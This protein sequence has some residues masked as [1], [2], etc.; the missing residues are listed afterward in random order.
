[1]TEDEQTPARVEARRG[2]FPVVIGRDVSVAQAGGQLF[3][4]SGGLSLTQGAGKLLVTSGDLSINQ[5]GG[6][7]LAAGGDISISQ[8]GAGVAVAR[9][10]RVERSYVGL[11]LGRRVE[12]TDD[13]RLVLDREQAVLVGAVAGVVCALVV[14]LLTRSRRQG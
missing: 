3:L 4:A 13:S 6:Q 5:G 10:I 8:G 11:A 2:F 7:F 12:I 1:M 14:G 9:D